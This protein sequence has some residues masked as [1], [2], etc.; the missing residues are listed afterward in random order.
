MYDFNYGLESG[1]IKTDATSMNRVLINKINEQHE[2]W[3]AIV[4]ENMHFLTHT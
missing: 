4:A 1:M 2:R 3:Q